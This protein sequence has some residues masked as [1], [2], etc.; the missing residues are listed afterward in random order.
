M[1]SLF[2]NTPI[3]LEDSSLEPDFRSPVLTQLRR[4]ASSGRPSGQHVDREPTLL[5]ADGSTERAS[6]AS[7]WAPLGRGRRKAGSS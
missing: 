3:D 6:A 5:D 4:P 7:V 1:K 2:S